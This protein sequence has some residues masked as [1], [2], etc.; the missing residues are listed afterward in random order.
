MYVMRTALPPVG[1]T[2]LH[3]LQVV[4]SLTSM[5]DLVIP[6]VVESPAQILFV[7]LICFYLNEI[8]L[9]L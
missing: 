1:I 6:P 8:I 2:S 4:S 5:F 9:F 7:E 3:M